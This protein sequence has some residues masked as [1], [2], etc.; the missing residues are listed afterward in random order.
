MLLVDGPPVLAEH[1]FTEL[2][3]GWISA[4]DGALV[5][6]VGRETRRDELTEA[7]ALL[8]AAKIPLIGLIWN[9]RTCP[10][11]RARLQRLAE[12]L[13]KPGR[14]R[15]SKPAVAEVEADE[16]TKPGEGT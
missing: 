3:R 1:G 5:V 9:E 4:F 7:V 16:S 14:G 8:H 12:R 13:R 6:V 10:P 11:L 15:R 2:R